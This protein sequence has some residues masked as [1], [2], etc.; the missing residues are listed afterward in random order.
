MFSYVIKRIIRRPWLSLVGFI[1]AGVFCFILCYLVGYRED[2]QSK[3]DEVRDSYEILCV[4]TDSRGVHSEKLSLNHRFA[5][6]VMD[7]ENGLGRYV[8]KANMTIE[9]KISYQLGTG[10]MIG[11]NGREASEKLNPAMGGYCDYVV[12]DFFGS[13]EYICL[14]SEENYDTLSGQNIKVK[15]SVPSDGPQDEIIEFTYLVVG[16]YRGQGTD[17]YVP[18]GTASKLSGSGGAARTDSLSF[19]LADNTKAEEMMEKAMEVFTTVDPAS[20]SSR[21][22]LTV[23][24]RQYKASITEMEQNIRRTDYLLPVSAIL[25]LAA[26]FLIGFLAARGETRTYALMRTLGVSGAGLMAMAIA[27]QVLL[28]AVSVLTVGLILGRVGTAFIYFLCHLIGCA[29]A[30]LRPA[31]SA[32][33]RL[34]YEQD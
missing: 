2:L 21:P 29:L 5:D 18:Y 6:F 9:F 31:S 10:T 33:T 12:E 19:V 24:D 14:V 30:M 34:L 28:P 8:K 27:E 11:I 1:M 20:Y 23:Q 13:T 15:V 7:E 26:G 25:S 17:L 16:Q 4:V 3:L 22:A 32:P